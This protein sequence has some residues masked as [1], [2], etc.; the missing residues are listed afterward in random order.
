M[1]KQLKTVAFLLICFLFWGCSNPSSPSTSNT[2]TPTSTQV[3]FKNFSR[4]NTGATTIGNPQVNGV[5]VSG[6]TIYA[7]TTG[8]LSVSTTGGTSWTNYTTTNGLGNNYVLGV[9]VSGTTIYAATGG[10]LSISQ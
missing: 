9:A 7:A 2:T 8:G 6:T 4:D 1:H 10:G 3:T 5:A